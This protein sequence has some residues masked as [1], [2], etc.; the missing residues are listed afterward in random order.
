VPHRRFSPLARINRDNVK[1]L[2]LGRSGRWG[3]SRVETVGMHNPISTGKPFGEDCQLCFCLQYQCL[4]ASMQACGCAFIL[5]QPATVSRVFY[6]N[7]CKLALPVVS[8]GRGRTKPPLL[9]WQDS[10]LANVPSHRRLTWRAAIWRCHAAAPA[11]PAGGTLDKEVRAAAPISPSSNANTVP[12][13]RTTTPSSTGRPCGA[14]RS[15]EAAIARVAVTS[16]RSL[17]N[18]AGSRSAGSLTDAETGHFALGYVR[19]SEVSQFKDRP[20]KSVP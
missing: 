3:R 7:S 12:P 15:L 16:P 1:N 19:R 13:P 20:G 2:K 18:A 14:S 8:P 4:I 11:H 6:W 17:P 5:S 9:A 10:A